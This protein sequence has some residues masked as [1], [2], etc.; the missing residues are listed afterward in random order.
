[1]AQER[2]VYGPQASQFVVLDGPADGPLAVL[3]HGGWWRA[4]HTLDLMMPLADDLVRRGWRTA[5]VEFRRIDGD[6]GGWPATFDDVLAAL[7][8]LAAESWQSSPSA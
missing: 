5:N 8:A 7:E 1:M 6:G 4:R 2:L 3:L